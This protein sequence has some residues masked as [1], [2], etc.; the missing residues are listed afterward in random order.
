MPGTLILQASTDEKLD[1]ETTDR[2][3]AELEDVVE[4]HEVFDKV[5]S[6]Y[7]KK[8]NVTTYGFS[9]KTNLQEMASDPGNGRY[10]GMFIVKEDEL[11]SEKF[12]SNPAVKQEKGRP[13]L[14]FSV[15]KQNGVD[16][17]LLRE[18][19]SNEQEQIL[20][21][22]ELDFEPASDPDLEALRESLG[23]YPG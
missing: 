15:L 10:L 1:E 12:I 6:Y 13:N 5:Q 23:G 4:E 17:I 14:A 19:A 16:R 21:E 8:R 20:N 9:V 22:L 18:P 11:I 2:I 3:R 7:Q